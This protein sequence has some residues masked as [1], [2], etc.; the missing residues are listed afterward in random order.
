VAQN[1]S[2]DFVKMLQTMLLEDWQE[3]A[4]IDDL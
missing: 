1:Y 3:R 4:D 2:P